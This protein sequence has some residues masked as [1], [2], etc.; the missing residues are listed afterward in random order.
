[1][2]KVVV[3]LLA[4]VLIGTGASVL[5]GQQPA[6]Q[7]PAST[8]KAAPAKSK[9]EELLAQALKDNPDIRVAAAKYSEAEAELNRVRLQVLQKLLTVHRALENAQESVRVWQDQYDRGMKA[10]KEGAADQGA[11]D[12]ARTML[13]QAKTKLAEVEGEVSYLIGKQPQAKTRAEV[14]QWRFTHIPDVEVAIPYHVD[15]VTLADTPVTLGLTLTKPVQGPLADKIRQALDKPISVSY[16]DAPLDEVLKD[17][18]QFTGVH[19]QVTKGSTAGANLTMQMANLPFGAA[20]QW[21][22]DALPGHRIVV[23]EYGLLLTTEDRVPPGALLLHD[24]WKGGRPNEKAKPGESVTKNPPANP[25][26]GTIM[27]TDPSGL[28]T[29]SI[30][31]DAGLAKGHTLEVYRLAPSKYLGTIRILE[32][33]PKE[34]VGQPMGRMTAP[35][36]KGDRVV[37]RIVGN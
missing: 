35:L 8:D 13:A 23:R 3:D 26:E 31:S 19:I 9:L 25:L 18:R 34:A 29:I 22:E 11:L 16:K 5:C 30:G 4:L 28:V 32:V 20:L 1:M 33:K 2:R 14:I 10:V 7:K 12:N 6:S 27:N 24:F 36:Q 15:R 37:N 21:L 17:F